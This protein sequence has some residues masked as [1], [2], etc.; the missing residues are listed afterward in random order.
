V[1]LSLFYLADGLS[2]LNAFQILGL[3]MCLIVLIP[4]IL[5]KKKK[6]EGLEEKEEL[7]A[8]GKDKEEASDKLEQNSKIFWPDDATTFSADTFPLGASLFTGKVKLYTLDQSLEILK[9]L[10]KSFKKANTAIRILRFSNP[11]QFTFTMCFIAAFGAIIGNY[12]S[13]KSLVLC[14]SMIGMFLPGLI[15]RK[16]FQKIRR[17]L[18]THKLRNLIN[19]LLISE[20]PNLEETNTQ[21]VLS[22]VTNVDAN[23]APK[24][25]AKAKA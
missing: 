25:V 24:V 8:A 19:F 13:G 18:E 2:Y 12:F 22:F 15:R 7:K 16:I 20:N 11:T 1:Y 3:A 9:Q 10:R 5:S 4:T 21:K 14:A 17:K 23:K 6:A